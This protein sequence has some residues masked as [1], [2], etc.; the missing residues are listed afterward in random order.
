MDTI[1][2]TNDPFRA[3]VAERAGVD[4]VMVDLE[5]LGKIERQGSFDTLISR[6]ALS[7]VNRLRSVLKRAVL[8][9]RVNPMHNDSHNEIRACTAAGAEV[10]MLPMI[11]YP[12]EARQF[13]EIVGGCTKTCLLLET[14][15]ALAR[16]RD[17]LDV[18]GIDEVHI[19]L[20]DLHLALKLDF[21]FEVVSGGLIDYMSQAVRERGLRFGIGGI[22]RL[23]RGLLSPELILGEYVRLGSS[24]VILSRDFNRIFDESPEELIEGV[25]RSELE[26]LQRCVNHMR[27]L[28]PQLQAANSQKLKCAVDEIL[29]MRGGGLSAAAGGRTFQS[30]GKNAS[31]ER[32]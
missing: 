15:A 27:R 14:G 3:Q 5:I 21:M 2:I 7:D 8:M 28:E 24:Q 16:L 31:V 19:G 26:E 18:P 20:N 23:G 22:A 13:V 6:H 12:A 25:F 30:G 11:S 17:I 9:V 4:R 29:G 10:L 1:F 32:L